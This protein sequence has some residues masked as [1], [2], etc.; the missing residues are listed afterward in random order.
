MQDCVIFDVDGTLFDT[1]EGIRDCAR[2]ALQQ[3]GATFPEDKLNLFIGPSLYYS[4]H[5]TVGLSEAESERGVE[6]Y[7]SRYKKTGI[8]MSRPYDG[9]PELLRTLKK[10]GYILTVASSKPLEMV[11]YLLGKYDMRR[12]FTELAAAEFATRTSDKAD[13]VRTAALGKRNVM[14]GDTH[15]DID[16]AHR[17]G[18]PVIAA[19]YGFG[20]RETLQAADIIA[21]TPSQ[22]YECITK[23]FSQEDR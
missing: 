8:D 1:G 19:A 12:Y 15:F 5:E 18:V 10:E 11:E 3:L 7:R 13:Y 6:L 4:F 22:V 23:F 9:V 17:A 14:V 21:D 20:K 2:Y 16:G